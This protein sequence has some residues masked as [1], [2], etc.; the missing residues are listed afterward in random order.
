MYALY[1]PKDFKRWM[2]QGSDDNGKEFVIL[3]PENGFEYRKALAKSKHDLVFSD[4][5]GSNKTR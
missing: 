4:C 3:D 2:D 1:H 5:P